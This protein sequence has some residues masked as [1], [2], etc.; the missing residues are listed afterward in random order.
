MSKE[1]QNKNLSPRFS[2]FFVAYRNVSDAF[3][4]HWPHRKRA[5]TFEGM[6]SNARIAYPQ[7]GPN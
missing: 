5:G 1:V 4:W 3:G 6:T 7:N 2:G